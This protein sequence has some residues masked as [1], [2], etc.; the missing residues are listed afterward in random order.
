M[1]DSLPSSIC[2]IVIHNPVKVHVRRESFPKKGFTH[3]T[4]LRKFRFPI[5]IGGALIAAA[6][7]LYFSGSKILPE[8]IQ[9]A[10]GMRNVYRDGQVASSDVDAAGTA[11]VAINA[12]LA[13]SEFKSL[14]HNAAF[15]EMLKSDSF[16]QLSRNQ[17][18]VGLLA[19]P[20]FRQLARDQSFA[21]LLNNSAFQNAPGGHGGD[22]LFAGLEQN[23]AYASLEK[24]DAFAQ[25]ASNQALVGLTRSDLFVHLVSSASFQSLVKDESFAHLAS[26]Q[27][28]QNALLAGS[29]ANLANNLMR[30]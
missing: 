10:I 25:L 9:G 29:A 6:A 24:N 5:L 30:E 13:S 16:L 11:P 12:V 23:A 27:S 15:Q 4:T 14:A 22:R 3:M 19:N 20:A 1:T 26:M 7:L 17:A 21:A 2:D 28:F 18:F 8:K